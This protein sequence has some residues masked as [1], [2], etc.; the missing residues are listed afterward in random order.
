MPARFHRH[1]VSFQYPENWQLVPENY[2]S[3]WAV[4]VQSP[5]TAFLTV[6]CDQSKVGMGKLADDAL[7]ILGEEYKQMDVT[8]FSGSIAGL[9]AIG[10]DVDFFSFDLT[11]SCLIR[12]IT[13]DDG[14]LLLVGQASDLEEKQLAVIRAMIASIEIDD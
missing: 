11:N 9:P 4:T 7:R 3:G 12:A 13:I 5:G 10:H 2:Q 14:V 1:G 6:T 8:P